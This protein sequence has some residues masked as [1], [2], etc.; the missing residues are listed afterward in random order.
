MTRETNYKSTYAACFIGY[1]TQAAVV[2]MPPLLFIIFSRQFGISLDKISLLITLNF[3]TQMLVDLLSSK[4]L[5]LIG[6]RLCAVLA[7][8]FSA[9]GLLLLGVLPLCMPPFGG[10]VVAFVLMAIG[11]GLMEVLVSPIIDAI[12]S[13]NKSARMSLLHSVYCWGAVGVIGSTTLMNFLLP[14]KLWYVI[15]I[16]WAVIPFVNTFLFAAVPIPLNEEESGGSLKT[17]FRSGLFWV[18]MAIML[19]GGAAEQAVAQWASLFTE[20][21]LGVSKAVG[22]ILGAGLFI[23][24]MGLAR[25][26]YGIFGKRLRLKMTLSVCAVLN[27]GGLLLT[28]L[29]THPVLGFVGCALC[30]LSIGIAWPGT[31]SLASRR[32][33]GGGTSMF[34]LLALGGDIGC[35]LGPSVVGALGSRL[36]VL[37]SPLKSGLLYAVFFPV[38]MLILLLFVRRRPALQEPEQPEDPEVPEEPQQETLQ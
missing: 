3:A 11:G 14:E 2:N 38:V 25:L 21:A 19:C 20:T 31:L 35:T 37:G 24:L 6:Y 1:I 9:G 27:I 17:L 26:S 4:F 7:N 33:K 22:D 29:A 28:S 18:M 30:G 12:P 13:D 15:P 36:D 32:V 23:A 10:L 8:V 34:A 16:V 5:P